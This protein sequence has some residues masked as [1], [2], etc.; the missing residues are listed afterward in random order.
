DPRL[1]LLLGDHP[2]AWRGVH[3]GV[4]TPPGTR[5]APGL[6][7]FRPFGLTVTL[8]DPPT[9]ACAQSARSAC[10]GSP[11]TA[12]RAGARLARSATAS[13]A[14]AAMASERASVAA[15]PYSSPRSSCP[16]AS[17]PAMPSATPTNASRAA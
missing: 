3:A 17:A 9:A 12:R 15:T 8:I 2:A 14:T 6:H 4:G 5:P 10:T 11:V 7:S 1:D 16:P 13:I